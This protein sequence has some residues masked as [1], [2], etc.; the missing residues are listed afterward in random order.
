[1]SIKIKYIRGVH[2]RPSWST[3]SYGRASM[4]KQKREV[5]Y[6]CE[7]ILPLLQTILRFFFF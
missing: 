3:I 5:H 1:M 6:I 7:E 2:D 4:S